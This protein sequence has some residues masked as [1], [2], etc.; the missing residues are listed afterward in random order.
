MS[1]Y[2]NIELFS[3]RGISYNLYQCL[4]YD[5]QEGFVIEDIVQ[6]LA[7]IE[8]ERGRIEE[9]SGE[10]GI[11]ILELA[12]GRFANLSGTSLWSGW[13]AG[14]FTD[15][16]YGGSPL[17]LADGDEDLIRQLKEGKNKTWRARK[18]EEF[19]LTGDEP[20]LGGDKAIAG[21]LEPRCSRCGE[22]ME[23]M[24]GRTHSLVPPHF[25]WR[26]K[27]RKGHQETLERKE[28]E[29]DKWIEI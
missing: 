23:R 20:S 9:G 14:T 24:Y 27:C 11:W 12:D 26:Y 19:G 13:D 4:Y 25:S 29:P 18:D 16:E 5:P 22:K 17:T 10:E 15:V 2:D 6:V 21:A 7:E 8:W 3:K 28:G 1:Y